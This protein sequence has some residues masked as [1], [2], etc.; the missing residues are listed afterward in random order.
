MQASG[1]GPLRADD[2]TNADGPV[3]ASIATSLPQNGDP[4]G[5]RKSLGDHGITYALIYT[6]DVLSN[7]SGG[8]KRGTIDQGKVEG[9]LTV[10]LEKLAGW[11]DLTLYANA[12]QI[13]NTGRIRRDYVGGMNTIAAIEAAPSTRLSEL[14]LERKFLMA[15]SVSASASSPPTASSSTAI[16]AACSC[17]A[18]GRR[19]RRSICRAVDQPIRCPRQ[20]RACKFNFGKDVSLLFAV[21]NGDPAGPCAGDR[22]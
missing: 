1:A 13:H 19:S 18:T 14:W 2:E 5:I 16:S 9:Q 22:R 12:F 6:N 20:A 21:F 4:A 11:Q 8:N 7:L 10:D 15:P 3:R 17:R